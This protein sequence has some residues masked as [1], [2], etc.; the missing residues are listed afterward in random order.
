MVKNLPSNKGGAISI[1]G[2]GTEIPHASQPK[3]H[4]KQ[5]QYCNKFNKGLKKIPHKKILK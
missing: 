4:K 5:K 2:Q 3:K 1:P